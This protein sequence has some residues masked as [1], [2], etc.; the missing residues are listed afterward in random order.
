MN[1]LAFDTSTDNLGIALKT[2][3]GIYSFSLSETLKHS[4]KLLPLTEML[5]DTAGSSVSDINLV[6]CAK[7][8][9]SFTGLRIGMSTAKGIASALSIPLVSVP[10]LDFLASSLY[11]FDGA[12]L[13]VIDAKKKRYYTALFDNG[14]RKSEYLDVEVNEVVELI[15]DYD[16]ILLTGPDSGKL[17]EEISQVLAD[18]GK[19]VFNDHSSKNSRIISCLETGIDMYLKGMSDPDN[20]GPI[21]VRKSDA[22]EKSALEK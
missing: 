13:P 2:E 18:R 19:K 10:T 9:G 17:Y 7:G 5:I 6:V 20:S 21:Y 14:R 15:R 4:E 22:E 1:T 3:K 12:V 8:P 16:R 11:I